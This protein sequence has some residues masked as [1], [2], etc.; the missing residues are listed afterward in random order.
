[1]TRPF[2]VKT[3]TSS[4]SRS[5]F[6]LCMNWAGSVTSACQSMIRFSQSM[7]AVGRAVLVRPVGGDAPLGPLVHLAG[8]DLHLDRLAHRADDRGVQALVEVELGH[9]DV[10]LEP[11]HHRPPPTV[12]AAERGVAVLRRVDD[13]PDRDEVEDVVELAALDD[14]LLV[15]APQVLAPAGDLGRDADLGE[16]GPHLGDRRREVHL[17]LGRPRADEVVELG[18]ALRV[19]RGEGQV[20]EL[21]L[22]L[23]HAEAVGQRGV[24]VER[25]LGDALLLLG[26]HRR[27]R[28]HVVQPV[29]ELD[30]QHPQVG[31][32]RHQHLAHRGGLLGLAG[33]ELDAVELGDAVD[34]GRDLGAEVRSRRPAR[35]ISVSSTASC[36]RAAATDVSSRPISAMIRA[37]ASGWLM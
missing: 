31:G 23:L 11:P 24:D 28:A 26:R 20:L 14:H 35:V 29:G 8:A 27:D 6:R 25:L 3:K 22:H 7:S 19:Q 37:T 12:D 32:H 17:A 21:L 9:R 33:V 30:E 34:D 15:E 2:G 5:V 4:C 1:M 36:S 16:P 10:V 18:E 13:D